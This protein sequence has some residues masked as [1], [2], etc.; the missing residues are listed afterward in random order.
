MQPVERARISSTLI[1]HRVRIADI[2]DSRQFASNSNESHT[3]MHLVI[4]VS[5]YIPKP[6]KIAGGEE[7]EGKLAEERERAVSVL[8]TERITVPPRATMTLFVARIKAHAE[9]GDDIIN[10]SKASR[11]YGA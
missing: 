4:V 6:I 5:S 9:D 8:A 7:T 3:D 1:H 2:L 10:A 11:L